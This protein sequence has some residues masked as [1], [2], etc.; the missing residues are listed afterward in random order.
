MNH[1]L[2]ALTSAIGLAIAAPAP[3]LAQNV[4]SE[5]LTQ[6]D[7]DALSSMMGGLF[8]DAEPL[9]AEEE[10]RLPVA[11]K[12]VGKL[13]PEGTY[14]KMMEESMKPM[15]QGIM[16]N[17]ADQPVFV[18][19]GLTGLSTSE[20]SEL[21]DAQLAQ[22]LA[23]LDPA[24]EERNAAMGEVTVGMVTDVMNQIEPAYRVGLTRAYATRFTQEE[25]TELDGFFSTK[26]GGRYAAESFLIYADPQVMSAMNDM[27][28]AMMEMMPAMMGQMAEVAERFPEGR[29][30]SQLNANEQAQLAELL[31]KSSEELSAAEPEDSTKVENILLTEPTSE[32]ASE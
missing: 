28:P 6:D 10:A 23:M 32:S 12:V 9:T 20:L 15:M 2:L 16:G 29:K 5:A 17:F 14:A 13:F 21:D 19:A 11:Q 1:S 26:T 22:A 30:F 8:G 25:L 31:G 27:M 3:L 7:A 24:A 4:E 18:V